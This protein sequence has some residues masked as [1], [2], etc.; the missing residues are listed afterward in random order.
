MLLMLGL[1]WGWLLLMLKLC[2]GWLL[3]VLVTAGCCEVLQLPLWL[4]LTSF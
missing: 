1:C 4:L 3:L 2:W